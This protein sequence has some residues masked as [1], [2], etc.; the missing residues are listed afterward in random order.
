MGPDA[1]SN[2]HGRSDNERRNNDSKGQ[3]VEDILQGSLKAAEIMVFKAYGD[4]AL[5]QLFDDKEN[6]I[7]CLPPEVKPREV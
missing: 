5:F 7:H 3:P 6:T 4:V 1:C 2:D